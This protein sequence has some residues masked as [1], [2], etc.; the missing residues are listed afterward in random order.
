MTKRS[1]KWEGELATPINYTDGTPL[2]FEDFDVKIDALKKHFDIWVDDETM[3]LKNIIIRLANMNKIPAFMP[4]KKDAVKELTY[5]KY[6]FWKSITKLQ[7][8]YKKSQEGAIK[9]YTGDLDLFLNEIKNNLY[10][11]NKDINNKSEYFYFDKAEFFVWK[12]YHT[13]NSDTLCKFLNRE[14]ASN[15]L[16][17]AEINNKVLPEDFYLARYYFG[18]TIRKLEDKYKGGHL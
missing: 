6:I 13:K 14:K 1:T 5:K 2:K 9:L 16:I 8:L 7:R 17:L 4:Q 15:P 11:Y 10:V 12:K 3:A 18:K